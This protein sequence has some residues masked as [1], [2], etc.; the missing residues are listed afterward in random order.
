MNAAGRQSGSAQRPTKAEVNQYMLRDLSASA[1]TSQQT[2]D[3]GRRQARMDRQDSGRVPSF[4][5]GGSEMTT[6]LS[7]R[8]WQPVA[9]GDHLLTAP[10]VSLSSPD[11][12]SKL[13]LHVLLQLLT[14]IL[15]A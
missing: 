5:R 7:G 1:V 12:V 3:V 15:G 4:Q 14:Y 11:R 13:L 8:P 2:N 6:T 10:M 9:D